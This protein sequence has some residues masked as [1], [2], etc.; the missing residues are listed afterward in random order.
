MI[1]PQIETTA[2][3]QNDKTLTKQPTLYAFA[4]GQHE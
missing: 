4:I 1:N 3:I 2:K